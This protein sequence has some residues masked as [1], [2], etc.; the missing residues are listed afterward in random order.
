[1]IAGF[2]P[3]LV[4]MCAMHTVHLGVC[5]WL[6]AS[7]MLDLTDLH[8]FGEGDLAEQL[9]QL[10]NSFNAWCRVQSIELLTQHYFL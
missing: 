3:R 6:N 2:T 8:Y 4:R 10:K 5:Q 7:A 1:M 9:D